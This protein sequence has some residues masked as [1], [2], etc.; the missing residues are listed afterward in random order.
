MEFADADILGEIGFE[1]INLCEPTILGCPALEGLH[2]EEM[3]EL[4]LSMSV[5]VT[6][7]VLL[8]G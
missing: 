4:V 3:M 7:I 6:I 2:P 5:P 8:I 1:V